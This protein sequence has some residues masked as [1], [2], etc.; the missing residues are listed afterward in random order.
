MSY[1]LMNEEE[2]KKEKLFRE[3][4]T[5]PKIHYAYFRH[6]KNKTKYFIDMCKRANVNPNEES[7]KVAWFHLHQRY[8]RGL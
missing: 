4:L 2:A 3:K 7:T 1:I 6:A 8:M 5:E